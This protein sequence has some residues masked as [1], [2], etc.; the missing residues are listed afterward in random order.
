LGQDCKAFGFE[1][2]SDSLHFFG[3]FEPNYAD[4]IDGKSSIRIL[5]SNPDLVREVS[6]SVVF[7][8]DIGS[9]TFF[10]K[11]NGNF[12][13]FFDLSF[14]FDDKFVTTC[15]NNDDWG[16]LPFFRN[17]KNDGR[18]SHT[19]KWV[20]KHGGKDYVG[21]PPTSDAFIDGLELCGLRFQD[22]PEL[23]IAKDDNEAEV[24]QESTPRNFL[25]IDQDSC[26]GLDLNEII[27]II[28]EKQNEG[29]YT[30]KTLILA[31]GEYS[32]NDSWTLKGLKD[33]SIE[34]ENYEEGDL[35]TIDISSERIKI[36]IEN[37]TNVDIK[38]LEIEGGICG[39]YLNKSNGC[40]I[41]KNVITDTIKCGIALEDSNEQNIENNKIE[42]N[43]DR[44]I[45][46]NLLNASSNNLARNS[47]SVDN[48]CY[49]IKFRS[50]N[51]NFLD[52]NPNGLISVFDKVY[53][54]CIESK[55]FKEIDSNKDC[56]RKIICDKNNIFKKD[57]I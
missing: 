36:I 9:V 18:S 31:P 12:P 37:C 7:E 55:G 27:D 4:S 11:K 24:I 10:W 28:K 25:K 49:N 38:G 48:E 8:K 54:I 2:E 42:S 41:S 46:I 45:G 47:I 50:K 16:A 6:A 40:E 56:S 22:G 13:T 29:N 51:N 15:N 14:Y 19:L 33:L 52:N 39:I 1:N 26:L 20:L 21:V 34:C 30:I 43:I 17:F 5:D 44:S 57:E 35:A 32:L 3:D 53:E 23:N